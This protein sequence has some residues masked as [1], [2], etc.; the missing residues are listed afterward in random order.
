MKETHIWKNFDF[1]IEVDY[2]ME[3]DI[4]SSEWERIESTVTNVHGDFLRFLDELKAKYAKQG[5]VIREG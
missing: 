3:A 5:L 2:D 4:D 1:A